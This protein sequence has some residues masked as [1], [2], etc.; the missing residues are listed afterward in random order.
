MVARMNARVV[1][2]ARRGLFLVSGAP[3]VPMLSQAQR[4]YLWAKHPKLAAE[5]EAATPKGKDLPEHVTRKKKKHAGMS[6]EDRR[7]N[8]LMRNAR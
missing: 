5:F 8:R 4:R 2:S 7:M 1:L 6:D 3:T